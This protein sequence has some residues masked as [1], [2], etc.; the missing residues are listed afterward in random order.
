MRTLFSH[1]YSISLAL[2]VGGI[3]LFT[4]IVTPVIFRSYPRDLSGDIV[5]R[6]FPYY[7]LY[8]LVV[9]AASL[10]M[11]LLSSYDRIGSGYRLSLALL[12]AAVVISLYTNFRLYPYIS[13]VKQEVRSFEAS[14]PD[15]PARK[16]FRALHAVSAV[17]N[18]IMLA[19]G[20]TLIILV[21]GLKKSLP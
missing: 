5:G 1:I 17:L 6:L 4:F 13:R 11:L 3:F 8:C 2:W 10:G 16:R 14:S 19:D 20:V 21:S 18:L 9:A 12:S 7:F 15:D